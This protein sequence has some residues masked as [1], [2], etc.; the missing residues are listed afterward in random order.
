[1]KI[2]IISDIHVDIN[3]DY[4]VLKTLDRVAKEEHCELVLIAGDIH[5]NAYQSIESI[6][7]LNSFGN[8]SYR[9]VPG[10]HDLWNDH[11]DLKSTDKIYTLFLQDPNCLCE[12]PMELG[13]WVI[14]G[15][16]GW[17][18]Y[19][20]GNQEKYTFDDFEKMQMDGRTWQDKIKNCWTS[21]NHGRTEKSL[22]ILEETF[23][24][25]PDKKKIVVTHML[26]IPEFCVPEK[27][28]DE[29]K[30]DWSYFNAFLGSRQYETLYQR[31]DV[32]Y[33]ICGHVHYRKNVLKN[34]TQ[35]LCRCLNYCT[36]WQ[37]EKEIEFQ[38]RK[39][40]DYI[41]I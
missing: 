8:V 29:Q 36:E 7:A 34:N 9:Y 38:I 26:P 4:D 40:L 18:D 17:Y 14:I 30:P 41:E 21:D 23:S 33:A 15:D 39:A 10:N 28:L 1:M 31:Y 35:Y 19:S 6:A 20:F 12:K 13:D 16:V 5:N 11:I 32:K 37:G 24:R 2:G 25:Y 27:K 3:Q 22:K